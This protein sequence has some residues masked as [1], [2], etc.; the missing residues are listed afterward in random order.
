MGLHYQIGAHKLNYQWNNY[1]VTLI[2]NQLLIMMSHI[3]HGV[4]SNIYN[5]FKFMPS[6]L[7]SSTAV[8]TTVITKGTSNMAVPYLYTVHAWLQWAC[9][10]TVS[11]RHNFNCHINKGKRPKT[12]L[13]NHNGSTSHHIMSLVNTLG[14]GLGLGNITISYIVILK[15]HDNQ[16]RREI[17]QYYRKFSKIQHVF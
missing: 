16:Y 14:G 12:C 8:K 4:H 3:G 1:K 2:I 9:P 15:H 17:S 11:I 6:S 5:I 10:P 7:H 13:P